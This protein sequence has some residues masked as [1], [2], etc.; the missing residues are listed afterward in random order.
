MNFTQWVV[1]NTEKIV[2]ARACSVEDISTEPGAIAAQLARARQSS[3][4]VGE[5]KA[6]A[7]AWVLKT[8]A[9]AIQKIHSQSLGY[10]ADEMKAMAEA[11]ADYLAAIKMRDNIATTVA[12]LK[13][14]SFEIMN[15]RRTSR[16]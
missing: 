16:F 14:M 2:K 7:T 5:L 6:D 12:A 3:V 1:E 13:T 15:D 8:K 4:E 11:D 10:R 9:A